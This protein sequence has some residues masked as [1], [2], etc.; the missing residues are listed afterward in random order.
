M[1]STLSLTT[2][3]AVLL[4]G[5]LLG[6]GVISV[7]ADEP[8]TVTAAN[9]NA[10]AEDQSSAEAS[11]KIIGQ[12]TAFAGSTANA[13]ALVDGL[14]A[15]T[16]ISLTSTVNGQVTTTTFQP[17]TG[18]LGYGNTFIA[19]ALARQTLTHDGITSPTPAQIVVALNGGSFTGSSGQSLTFA[20]VLA[21]RAKGDGW[22][23]V[24]KTLDL[25][26]GPV[27]RA[28]HETTGEM[29]EMAHV[30]ANTAVTTPPGAARSEEAKVSARSLSESNRP[31]W[32]LGSPMGTP[33]AGTAAAAH[34][35]GGGGHR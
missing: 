22:G 34:V 8:I 10:A 13:T 32:P 16:S 23:D 35:A 17:A 30:S 29:K 7:R 18:A 12:F 31:S 5:V 24:A 21:L 4:A 14:R 27:V 1:N 33:G 11:S 15:G 6:F 2:R 25:K 9:L 20:G 28:A 3:T 26:L 19:L